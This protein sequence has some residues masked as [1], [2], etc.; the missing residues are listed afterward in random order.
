MAT[1]CHILAWRIPG[2]EEPVGCSLWGRTE[3]DSTEATQQQQQQHDVGTKKNIPAKKSLEAESQ[4][5]DTEGQQR[6]NTYH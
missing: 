4:E 1:P 2:T 5:G 3:S 6:G